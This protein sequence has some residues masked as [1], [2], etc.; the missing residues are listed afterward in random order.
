M[1]CA[2]LTD[3]KRAGQNHSVVAVS[4]CSTAS[5]QIKQLL[6]LLIV[7]VCCHVVNFNYRVSASYETSEDDDFH[8]HLQKVL[9]TFLLCQN[10][11]DVLYQVFSL[12][13][14]F[15]LSY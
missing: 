2:Q 1:L 15:I 7:Y 8:I 5:L 10:H 12:A 6:P 9:I 11:L 13:F 4:N 14:F 3:V